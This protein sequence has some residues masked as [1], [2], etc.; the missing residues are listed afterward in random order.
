MIDCKSSL[1]SAVDALNAAIVLWSR[2]RADKEFDIDLGARLLNSPMNSDPPS[3]RMDL[4]GR[5]FFR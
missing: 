5:V 3:T 2:G 4:V 1:K